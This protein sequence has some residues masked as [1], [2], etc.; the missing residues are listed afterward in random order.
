MKKKMKNVYVVFVCHDDG[1]VVLSFDELKIILD[2]EH[3][4]VEW[5][6][7]K[8]RSHE[9]YAVSGHDGKLDFKVADTDFPAKALENTGLS[10]FDKLFR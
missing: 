8:R 3:D 6:A 1:I 5:V 2:H 4:E 7:I 9:Q 10:F